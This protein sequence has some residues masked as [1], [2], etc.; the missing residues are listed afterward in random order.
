MA[1]IK[2]I[3][4]NA[5]QLNDAIRRFPFNSHPVNFH[6]FCKLL[7]GHIALLDEN[8]NVIAIAGGNLISLVDTLNKYKELYS[9]MFIATI[10][11]SLFDKEFF[12]KQFGWYFEAEYERRM[13]ENEAASRDNGLSMYAM[14]QHLILHSG[15][16]LAAAAVLL[17]S[18]MGCVLYVDSTLSTAVDQVNNRPHAR[19]LRQQ[20]MALQNKGPLAVPGNNKQ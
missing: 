17:V 5:N 15:A 6:D 12:D 10:D 16:L 11:A 19:A 20:G 4:L 9:P 1:T 2:T 13:Q 3:V 7:D 8:T 18:L 14:A